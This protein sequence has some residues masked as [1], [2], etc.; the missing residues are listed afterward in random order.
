MQIKISKQ[1]QRESAAT[2]DVEAEP[3]NQSA[4]N[5]S[6]DL[7]QSL[8]LIGQG[9]C[10]DWLMNEENYATFLSLCQ[11]I[12]DVAYKQPK[13]SSITQVKD[14]FHHIALAATVISMVASAARRPEMFSDHLFHIAFHYCDYG[15]CIY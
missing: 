10:D 8:S 15:F 6:S 14:E 9:S 7:D 5:K 3:S 2:A 1:G 4:P 11:G 13:R 12:V